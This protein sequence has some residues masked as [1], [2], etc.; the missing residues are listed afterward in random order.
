[1]AWVA[2]TPII[3]AFVTEQV[4]TK[5]RINQSIHNKYQKTELSARKLRKR[6]RAVEGNIV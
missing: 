4:T 6:Q 5:R 2:V 3:A 1:M